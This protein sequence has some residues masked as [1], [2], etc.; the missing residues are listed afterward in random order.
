VTRQSV[1]IGVTVIVGIVVGKVVAGATSG[2]KGGK[3]T[4]GPPRKN[5]TLQPGPF[6]KESI[7][8]HRGR[9]TAMEQRQVNELMGKHGCHTCGTKDPGTAR[10]GAIADHQPPQ[11][12]GEPK[13]F[14]PHCDHCKARQGGEV[15]QVL[16]AIMKAKK[17]E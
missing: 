17:E 13:I 5:S 3:T 16:R 7:P 12:L 9:P 2:G 10:G 1:A 6:A 4:R 8:G 14:L 15:A 11:A